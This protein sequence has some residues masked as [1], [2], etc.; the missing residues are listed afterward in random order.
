M[1]EGKQT[2]VT[3]LLRLT[4][5]IEDTLLVGM[6]GAMI[7]LTTAQ[8]VLRNVFDGA[9]IWADPLLR[10]AVIWVGMIGAMVATRNDRQIS[11]DAVS[12]F[13]PDLWK[14]RMR[15]VTDLF[16]AVV[17]AVVA[18]SAFRLMID[19]RAAGGLAIAKV[20][21][22][23]CESILPVAFAVIALRY[24][25]FAIKHLRAGIAEEDVP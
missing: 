18:W 25:L 11:I 22:W 16:T 24:L 17:S 14:A 1:A 9:I 8:I 10:V 20:P 23:V 7:V 15:V 3:R 21:V 6:L 13:L 2:A 4:G 5:L 19:D 12:R